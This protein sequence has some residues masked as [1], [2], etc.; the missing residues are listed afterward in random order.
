MQLKKEGFH[1]ITVAYGTEKGASIP[2]RDRFGNLTGQ[3]KD[4][5]GEIVITQVKGDF[6][7]SVAAATEGHFYYS[8]YDGSHLKAIIQDIGEYEKTEFSSTMAT[9]YDEKFMYPL[10]LGFLILILSFLIT[11]RQREE[12]E[13][14]GQYE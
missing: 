3:K 7:K 2:T 11:D 12:K 10:G 14:R 1:F 8:T 6:L 5:Q 9:Q 4:S 13:W